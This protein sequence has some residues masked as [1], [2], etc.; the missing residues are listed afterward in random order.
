[1]KHKHPTQ[2]SRRYTVSPL[3]PL[4]SKQRCKAC[5]CLYVFYMYIF[6]Q[7]IFGLDALSLLFFS[8]SLVCH[9]DII[10]A[11]SYQQ[12]L[13]PAICWRANPGWFVYP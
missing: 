3:D 8:Y 4:L 1:M 5:T 13:I 11:K 9:I 12:I 10:I 6:F 2:S 7:V